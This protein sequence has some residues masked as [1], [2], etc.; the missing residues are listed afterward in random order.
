MDSEAYDQLILEM[1]N[2]FLQP[3]EE[4]AAKFMPSSEFN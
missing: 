3:C 2:T 1:E 4:L